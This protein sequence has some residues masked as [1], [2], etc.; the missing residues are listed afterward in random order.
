MK[1]VLLL[2]F[3]AF[4]FSACKK[5]VRDT[6]LI[7]KWK[8]TEY[9]ADPGDGSGTWQPAPN[10]QFIEFVK[11]GTLIFSPTGQYDS[12]RYNVTSDSTMIFSGDSY[13]Y[14]MRY[15]L[16]GNLLTLKPQCIE[17][18]GMKYIKVSQ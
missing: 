18:C 3:V 2:V 1:R 7:G 9:L 8:L 17:A 13:D 5:E 14:P 15:N 4:A 6:D 12:K 16:S 10:S 11:D